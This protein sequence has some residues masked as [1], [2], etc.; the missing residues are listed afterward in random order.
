MTTQRIASLELGRV[1]A[2]IAVIAIHSQ[3]MTIYPLFNSEPWLGNFINQL[4]RFAVPFFFITSGYFLQPKLSTSPKSTAWRYCR[5]LLYLWLVWSVVYL[6]APFNLYQLSQQGW[7]AERTGYWNYL[8]QNPINALLEGGMVHLW[9][10]PA[11]IFAV[12]I[13]AVFEQAKKRQWLLGVAG[14]IYIYGVLAGSYQPLTEYSAPFFTRNGPFFSL[15]MVTIGYLVRQH[16]YTL[17]SMQALIVMLIGLVGHLTEAFVLNHFDIDFRIHDFLF[18]TPLWGL[19]LFLLLLANPNWGNHPL[20][21]AIANMTLGIYVIHLLIIIYMNNMSGFNG[22]EGIAKDSL[23]FVGA[24][25]V[26]VG[27]T[28]LL[29]KSP[30]KRLLFTR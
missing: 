8:A 30:L 12:A 27:L 2:I 21:F 18:S 3:L 6:L 25:V 11:L 16:R 23:V 26:S 17:T 1:I 10:L 7:L 29:N 14:A 19:G 24:I 4:S 9:F 5:P 13:I 15:L 22:L 20:I 28:Y